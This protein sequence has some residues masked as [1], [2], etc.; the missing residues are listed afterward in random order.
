MSVMDSFERVSV[1][2]SAGGGGGGRKTYLQEAHE[3]VMDVLTLLT[4]VGG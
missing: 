1:G 4:L 2:V 3:S